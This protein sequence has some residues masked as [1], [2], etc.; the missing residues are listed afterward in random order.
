M[1]D[2]T[3]FDT[4]IAIPENQPGLRA[5]LSSAGN[6]YFPHGPAAGSTVYKA[7]GT[8]SSFSTTSVSITGTIY[9]A[10]Q[11]SDVLHILSGTSSGAFHYSTFNM[12]TDALVVTNESAYTGGG[13]TTA[14]GGCIAV[15]SNGEIVIIFR[16]ANFASMGNDFI[17]LY[18]RIRSTGGTWGAATGFFDGGNITTEAAG[19]NA[20]IPGTSGRLHFLYRDTVG[21]HSSR[22]R[23]LLSNNTL[24]TDTTGG[25]GRAQN[26][27]YDYVG[28]SGGVSPIPVGYGYGAKPS[29]AEITSA[30]VPTI[31]T[32]VVID[33]AHALNFNHSYA[34]PAMS[35]DGT[36]RR[37]IYAVDAADLIYRTNSGSGWSSPTVL[38]D[39][40]SW[41][42]RT[43]SLNRFTRSGSERLAYFTSTDSSSP[44]LMYGEVELSAG[45]AATH[46]IERVRTGMAT[47]VCRGSSF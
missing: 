6:T 2:V 46:P 22:R 11:V 4:G 12:A 43:Y 21:N 45:A 29:T 39:N 19:L 32:A 5:F 10:V 17:R 16:G 23:T 14:E 36:T 25:I 35:Y 27:P 20:I 47:A 33:E 26:W 40:V 1:A 9:D 31:S 37:V 44:N 3:A 34:S 18:Y 7:T 8:P 41:M 38:K 30:D 28:T 15:R 24:G 42:V 13:G